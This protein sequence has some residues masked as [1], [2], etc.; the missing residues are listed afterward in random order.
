MFMEK[1]SILL[2][3]FCPPGFSRSAIKTEID[4]KKRIGILGIDLCRWGDVFLDKGTSSGVEGGDHE[5]IFYAFIHTSRTGVSS[6][7]FTCAHV[8]VVNCGPSGSPSSEVLQRMKADMHLV[9]QRAW[10]SI[11]M[12][13]GR[14]HGPRHSG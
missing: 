8:C 10:A 7:V 11:L 6:Y 14:K 3:V 5:L 1:I 13:G 2:L 4:L 9:V 12:N